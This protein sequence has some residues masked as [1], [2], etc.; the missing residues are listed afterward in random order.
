MN[1]F[2]PEYV[3]SIGEGTIPLNEPIFNTKP[4]FLAVGKQTVVA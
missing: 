1:A 4:F 3:A 2:V